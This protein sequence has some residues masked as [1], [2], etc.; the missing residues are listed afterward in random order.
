MTK[1]INEK[2][3][4]GDSIKYYHGSELMFEDSAR[5]IA[6]A[7]H[8]SAKYLPLADSQSKYRGLAYNA[9]KK[10]KAIDFS[11]DSLSKMK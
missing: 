1:L 6:H 5:Q 2:K 4:M 3:T 11:I 7:T 10:I 8:N 9:T